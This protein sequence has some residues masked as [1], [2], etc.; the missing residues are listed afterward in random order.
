M[1]RLL[2][3]D[4][5]E[6]GLERLFPADSIRI[7]L[8]DALARE[9]VPA[10]QGHYAL[11]KEI[12]ASLEGLLKQLGVFESISRCPIL[13]I[14]GLLN[15]GKS[16]LLATYLAPENRKRVL[17]GL[18]NN[19]GTHRFVLWLPA[20]WWNDAEL[21]STLI[22]FLS[23]L[24]GHPPEHLSADPEIAALQYNGRIVNSAIMR[25][26]KAAADAQQETSPQAGSA[27]A[28]KEGTQNAFVDP[29]LVPLIAY[30]VA[31]DELKL[32]LIDCPDIQTGFLDSGNS[33]QRGRE[34]AEKRQHQL[35][36]IGRLCSA[37]VVVCKLN[38]L[39]DEGLTHVLTTLRDAMPGVP[40][41][42]AVNKVKARY[43]PEVVYEQSRVLADRFG[44]RSIHAAYD[45]RSALAA[46]RVPPRPP[47]LVLNEAED[48]L[49]IFFEVGKAT[50][51]P[52][53]SGT[54][55]AYLHDLGEQLDAGTLSRESSR[56][57]LLQ[58]KTKVAAAIQWTEENQRLRETQI[59]DGWQAIAHACY[60]FMAERDASGN[61]VGL[62]LQ[63]SPAIVSQMADSLQRTAP[64][65]LRLSL[66]IDRTARQLQQAV[67]NSTARF[68][69]LQNASESVTRFTKRFKRG[70][71][72][73]VVTPERLAT[74]IRSS[75]VHDALHAMSAETL[76][77]RCET[78]MQ[79]FADED[80][81]LL[82]QEEL[83][84]W[85]R[86][87]WESMSFKDKLWRGT[88]PLAVMLGPLLAAV[89]VPFDGGGTAVLVF[90][91]AKELLA[92]AGIALV[93]TAAGTGGE[94]LKIVHRETPWRQLSDLFAL[95]CD[96]IGLPRPT[97]KELPSAKCV[98][99]TRQLLPSGLAVKPTPEPAVCAWRLS[100]NLINELQLS[101]KRLI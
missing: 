46:S 45:F 90:A 92:A 15:A 57:L 53:K 84:Q 48:A 99:Q 94:T 16:S 6:F 101:L 37:F 13:A 4:S 3:A 49:P 54:S 44:I 20:A 75:D 89:L 68:K 52:A 87:V 91:S 30:D 7:S 5:S 97:E 39:H 66:G 58:L 83:E 18:G 32:G 65:W 17:R 81:T 77:Q 88:Q 56:S 67:A 35:G 47:R 23:S 71:G 31:L 33:S 11:G 9:D 79:R 24:F 60:E 36:I 8:I 38:S 100:E 29:L 14:T 34:L 98:D 21:L 26:P 50:D 22:S 85:S 64:M 59:R 63:A 62:R 61:A 95:A 10:T 28:S 73:Q 82:N 41:L 55:L 12:H 74:A 51:A 76:V 96:S 78:A 93:T 42:L 43:A 1:D 40:R 72:A 70:E 25:E 19:S 27:E 2:S 80:K 86:Q 69:I